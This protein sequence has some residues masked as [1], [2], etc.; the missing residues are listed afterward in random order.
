MKKEIIKPKT[1]NIPNELLFKITL[2]HFT[3]AELKTLFIIIGLTFGADQ[4]Q[5]ES[6]ELSYNNLA[7]F[8]NCSR[9]QAINSVKSLELQGMIKNFK[10]PEKRNNLWGINKEFFG[11]NN[12]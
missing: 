8:L 4:E 5:K 1:A 3:A 10:T 12:G 6:V 2:L 7:D 9:Q 11:L